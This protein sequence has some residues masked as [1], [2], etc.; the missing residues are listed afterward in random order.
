MYGT[1]MRY[2]LKPGMEERHA[3]LVKE[4]EANKPAG[5]VRA[6]LYTLDS[7][8]GEYM[9]AAAHTDKEAYARDGQSPTQSAW[10]QRFSE[11]VDGEVSFNDGEITELTK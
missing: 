10:F 9:T 8:N 2:R 5:F 6:L 11:I 3:E 4:F 7:G 1:V